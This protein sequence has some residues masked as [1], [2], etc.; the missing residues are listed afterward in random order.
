MAAFQRIVPCLWFDAQADEAAEFYTSIFPNSRIVKRS[1]YSEVGQEFHGK[2]AGSVMTVE[3]ELDGCRFTGLNGG[4]MFQFSEAISL[5]ILC[6]DQA[7]VDHYWAR[8]T[9]GGAEQPCGWLKDRFGVSWQVVPRLFEEIMD[10]PNQEGIQ[11]AMAAM[12]T[13]QKL[14]VAALKSAFEG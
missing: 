14:D 1:H 10:S 4:P 7:E 11:R 13:M 5:Q 12:F 8:L 6:E 3:F 9:E 2:P